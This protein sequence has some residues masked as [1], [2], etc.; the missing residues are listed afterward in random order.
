MIRITASK[1]GACILYVQ[2][3]SSS[4]PIVNTGGG[5]AAL[6]SQHHIIKKNKK[7]FSLTQYVHIITV[8][9]YFFRMSESVYMSQMA[10]LPLGRPM[11][12]IVLLT[13][14]FFK[15]CSKLN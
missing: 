11:Y 8:M 5:R 14:P 15:T 9:D 13:M 6:L 4:V 7:V 3:S 10:I 2:G 12:E 1:L